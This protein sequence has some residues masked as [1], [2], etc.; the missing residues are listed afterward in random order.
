MSLRARFLGEACPPKIVL[1]GQA[2]NLSLSPGGKEEAMTGV[3][4]VIAAYPPPVPAR[5]EIK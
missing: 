1:L 3:P 4:K 2:G 5:G